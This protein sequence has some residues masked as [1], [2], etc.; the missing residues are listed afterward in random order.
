[1]GLHAKTRFNVVATVECSYINA[2]NQL[3]THTRAFT[4]T[5][6]LTYRQAQR[7]EDFARG[8][9]HQK[10]NAERENLKQQGA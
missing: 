5:L 7:A 3:I 4:A 1:M 2:N 8:V 6:Y 9:I 10:L